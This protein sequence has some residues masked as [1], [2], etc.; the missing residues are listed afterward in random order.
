MP[1]AINIT[2]EVTGLSELRRLLSPPESLY[3]EPWRRGMTDLGTSL[4]SAALAAAPARS[5]R[6][7]A[8]VRM[9]IQKKPFP[10]WLAVRL[11]A[12]RRGYPYPRLLEF[13]GKHHHR[14]WL[15]NS[16]RGPLAAID[17]TLNRIGHEILRRW[18][19]EH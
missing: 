16:A 3:A 15:Q 18:S 14:G 13:S 19:S 12:R 1:N 5:G 2:L 7:R 11:G 10:N 17:M 9:S 6:L 4:R 8:S